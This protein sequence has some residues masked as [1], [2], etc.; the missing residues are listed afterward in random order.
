MTNFNP[1]KRWSSLRDIRFTADRKELNRRALLRAMRQEKPMP[2]W[3]I[4]FPVG[5]SAWASAMACL[6]IFSAG[7]V[8]YAAEQ[9]LP[10]Q[11]LHPVKTHVTEE[12]LDIF[13][14]TEASQKAWDERRV[15]RRL[16]EAEAL[17]ELEQWTDEIE[18]EVS[19][20]LDTAFEDEF[21]LEYEEELDDWFEE[22]FWLDELEE[23]E[24]EI[25]WIEEEL[26]H[27]E[28]EEMEEVLDELYEELDE[29]EEELEFL[30]EEWEEDYEEW[31]N[32]EW[33]D[34][35]EEDWEEEEFWEE[36]EE[37]WE[38]DWEE[39]EWDLE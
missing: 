14:V 29:V 4:H 26:E 28:D 7:G 36:L 8:T 1:K 11:S 34:E 38:E 24:E 31:E 13:Y 3:R 12:I 32:E 9:S 37:A 10:G 15:Q 2:W 19:E 33:E 22:E 25:E 6:V 5:R 20:F 35:Y 16:E 21:L 17:K 18:Q 30:E 23:L 27:F 39:E